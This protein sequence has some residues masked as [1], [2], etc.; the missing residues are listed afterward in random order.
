ML[1]LAVGADRVGTRG[2]CW[3][4]CRCSCTCSC[5]VGAAT[6]VCVVVEQSGAECCDVSTNCPGKLIAVEE[7]GAE[8]VK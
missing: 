5:C 8:R 4:W 6:D 3:W 7:N 1:V 2:C